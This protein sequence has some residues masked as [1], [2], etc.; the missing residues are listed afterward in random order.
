MQADSLGQEQ[1]I[2]VR[3][4]GGQVTDLK[5]VPFSSVLPQNK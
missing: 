4:E 2:L 5:L 1:G 3:L